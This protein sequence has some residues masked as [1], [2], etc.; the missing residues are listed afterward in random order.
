MKNITAKEVV[1]GAQMSNSIDEAIVE[2]M[3]VIAKNNCT[4]C[5]LFNGEGTKMGPDLEMIAELSDLHAVAEFLKNPKIVRPTTAMQNVHLEEYEV[6]K[7][8]AM[9]RAMRGSKNEASAEVNKGAQI[10]QAQ[11]LS[12]HKFNGEGGT[13]GPDLTNISSQMGESELIESIVNPPGGMPQFNL[14]D[15]DLAELVKYLL[16]STA[17]AQTSEGLKIIKQKCISCHVY[18]GEGGTF[19]PDIT[20][21]SGKFDPKSL[22]EYINNP[23]GG[24]PPM[25]LS[26]NDLE[27]VVNEMMGL[28]TDSALPV[29][30]ASSGDPENGKKIL[31]AK[32]LSCHAFEGSGGTF[33]PDLTNSKDKFDTNSMKD[34]INNPQG[35]MPPMGLPENE[36]N[37]LAALLIGVV[38]IAEPATPSSIEN[39]DEGIKI[40]K[41]KCLSCHVV[42]NEGGAFGPD[43]TDIGLKMDVD[44]L[45]RYMNN[46][47]GGMPPMGL[48]DNDALKAS[49]YLHSLS[50]K[51]TSST[52]VVNTVKNGEVIYNNHACG[53][54][55]VINGR[56]GTFGPD[57]SKIGKKDRQWLVDFMRNPSAR[58][59]ITPLTKK[60]IDDVVDYMM[61]LK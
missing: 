38:A 9:F 20:N 33:G 44:G 3:K 50:V 17:L 40:V 11:C 59:P 53:S 2:G 54:C 58:M 39:H 13:F 51:E 36:L 12:C 28:S 22:G 26:D 32:C 60:E 35:G 14:P 46:P 6:E 47:T 56:G 24:M 48:S 10:Y 5:H 45:A 34:Y 42:N 7:I 41:E 52:T 31:Q 8:I 21:V 49:N 61:T 19:G 16:G 25:G 30:A 15:Q 1:M 27:A 37:D 55:H 18:K 4:S 43:L 57:L 29:A 23:A